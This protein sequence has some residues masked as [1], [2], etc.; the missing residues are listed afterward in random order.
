MEEKLILEELDK[1]IEKIERRI[2]WIK[3]SIETDKMLIFF[4]KEDLKEAK[5][6][7]KKLKKKIIQSMSKK[8]KVKEKEGE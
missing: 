2:F 1:K 5:K 7:R 8:W 6:I 4:D 3:G